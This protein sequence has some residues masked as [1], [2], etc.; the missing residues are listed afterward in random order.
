MNGVMRVSRATRVRSVRVDGRAWRGSIV[1]SGMISAMSGVGCNSVA[2]LEDY[3]IRADVDASST[4][5]CETNAEC[6]DLAT[7]AAASREKVPAV[8]VKPD[9]RCVTLKTVDCDQ[10][11]GDYLDDNAIVIGSLFSTKG[12]QSATNIQRQQSAMLAVNQI[13][14]VGGIP[15][16][17]PGQS[18]KLVLVSCDES[19]DLMRAGSHLIEDLK[20]PAIVGPNMSQDT[21]ELSRELSVPNGTVVMSPTAVASSITALID[22]DLT[23]LMVPTDV[24]RAPLMNSQIG[25]LE[26]RLKAERKVKYVKLGVVFRDDALGI[27]TRTGLNSLIINGEPISHPVN[28]GTNVRISAYDY[29]MPNQNAIVEEHLEFAPDIM[30]L[31][32]TAEAISHVMKP[33]EERWPARNP[34]PHYVLIDSV[35]VPELIELAAE[36]DELRS[37][38]RGTGVTS[39]PRSIPVYDSFKVDYQIAYPGS[40]IISGMGP[41]YDATYAIAFALAAT[42]MEPVSGASIKKGLRRLGDGPTSIEI[43]A[44]RVLQAFQRLGNGESITAIGTFSTLAWDR[45]GAVAGGTLEMWCIGA[46]SGKPVYQSSGLTFD[47]MTQEEEGTFTPCAP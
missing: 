1:L 15:G 10:V 23:W 22:D 11:T 3:S 47:I 46:P 30:V 34:R 45:D 37:R 6:T 21:I 16:A 13:N 26:A 24:Q 2:G 17:T 29:S 25:E 18:R 32:G 42:R 12:P 31:A 5:E 41:A 19:T 33:L 9:K 35:K 8:C 4:G 14:D 36:N 44:T 27:G 28:L 20:V 7:A 39:S 38:V 43:G 40:S